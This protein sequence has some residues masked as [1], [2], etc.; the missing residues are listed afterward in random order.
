M[1]FFKDKDK[2]KKQLDFL[3]EYDGEQHFYYNNSEKS[4]NTKEQFEK[5]QEKDKLKNAY[6]KNNN[7]KL[8][9]IPYYE[10]DKNDISTYSE[11]IQDKFLI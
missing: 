8:Y 9:R 2:D 11:L 10:F 3:L 1:L 7:I 6:C 4:W 5:T